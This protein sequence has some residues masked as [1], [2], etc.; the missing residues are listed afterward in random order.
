MLSPLIRRKLTFI[1]TFI[2]TALILHLLS[3]LI[4]TGQKTTIYFTL[5]PISQNTQE[6]T[7]TQ[8]LNALDPAESLSKI[9]ETLAG[10]AQNPAFRNE[11]L[12]TA[13]ISIPNFKK[14]ITARKQNRLNVFWTIKLF[15]EEIATTEEITNAFLQVFQTHFDDLNADSTTK[16]GI[17]TPS[18][19]NEPWGI[20]AAWNTA[21]IIFL[22]LILTILGIYGFETITN[23][24]SFTDQIKK[25]FKKSPTLKINKNLDQ[26]TKTLIEQ[27][28]LT[29]ENPKFIGTF[30]KANR[31]F[32]ITTLEELDEEDFPILIIKLGETK[33]QDLENLKAIL[34]KH[35]GI[36]IL[37]K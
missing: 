13:Q 18:I 2:L 37:E 5:K 32:S 4:P 14:R 23:R 12:H 20:P 30:P 15:E 29:F 27:F 36:I 10:W 17:T 1:T 25:I 9:A 35:T 11:I 8:S 16:Y 28:S 21:A 19:S 34:G 26:Q 22:S 6:E 7:T 33:T 31:M 3:N 24:I